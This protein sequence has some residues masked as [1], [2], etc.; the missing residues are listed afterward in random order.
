MNT[1]SPG[2]PLIAEL[3]DL[4]PAEHIVRI[5]TPK[6]DIGSTRSYEWNGWT[7]RVPPGVFTPGATSRMV[8]ERLLDGRIAVRGLVYAAMGVGLGVEAVAAGVAGAAKVYAL[9]VHAPSVECAAGHFAEFATTGGELVPGV[10]DLFDPVPEGERLDVV[11]FN[12]PAVSQRVSDD[13]D[14]VRNVCEG[15]VIVTRFFDQLVRRD[16]LAEGGRVYVALSN[17]ADLKA[18]VSHAVHIGLSPALEHRHDWEDGV[19]THVFRFTE[20][21][22]A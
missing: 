21:V 19:V 6:E 5:N 7:F 9:D 11:T 3:P 14:V 22:T 12:P 4:L 16:L 15:A 1:T 2:H 17:T 13:P 18:I 8:H 20:A 10:G